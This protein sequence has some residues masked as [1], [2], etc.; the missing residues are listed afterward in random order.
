MEKAPTMVLREKLQRLDERGV[1]HF[2][3]R[4][5]SPHISLGEFCILLVSDMLNTFQTLFR[6]CPRDEFRQGFYVICN[7][8][9]NINLEFWPG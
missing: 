8:K 9:L 1:N 5:T 3:E 7:A 4:K 6:V 2:G